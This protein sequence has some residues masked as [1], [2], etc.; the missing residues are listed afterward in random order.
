VFNT[1]LKVYKVLL[2]A[3][4]S[5]MRKMERKTKNVSDRGGQIALP[6]PTTTQLSLYVLSGEFKSLEIISFHEIEG[7]IQRLDEP[8]DTHR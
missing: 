4:L 1:G 7:P 5:E 2:I 6:W 8:E 3:L